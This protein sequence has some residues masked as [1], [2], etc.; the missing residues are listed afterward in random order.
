MSFRI[1]PDLL[2][3][4]YAMG[5]FPM[6]ESRNATEVHWVDPRRRGIFPLE[7]FHI[8]RS[9][10]RTIRQEH[11]TITTDRDFEGVVRGWSDRGLSARLALVEVALCV[12]LFVACAIHV[13]L[14]LRKAS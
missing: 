3:R 6:A 13:R 4:A 9:L 2:L 5:V 7:G 11:F 14:R 12:L 1:T 10:A 8:S